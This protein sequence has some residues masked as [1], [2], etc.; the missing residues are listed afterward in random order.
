MDKGTFEQ[1]EGEETARR[2]A[3][4]GVRYW[5]VVAGVLGFL[6]FGVIGG[7]A[8]ISEISGAVIASGRMV[9]ESSPK[10][11]QHREGGI[12][13]EI[14][15]QNG[16]EVSA[17]DLLIRLDDTIVR[18]ELAAIEQ[19]LVHL[20]AEEA[21]HA[22]DLA[23]EEVLELRKTWAPLSDHRELVEAMKN[24]QEL[25]AAIRTTRRLET[26]QLRSKRDQII[27]ETRSH[28]ADL[29]AALKQLPMATEQLAGLRS[30]AAEEFVSKASVIKVE[31][32]AAELEARV[33]RARASVSRS[34][35][36]IK[37]IELAISQIEKGARSE[38]LSEQQR[39][40]GALL[41][42]AEKR[43]AAV[44]VLE[45][46]EIRAPRAGK[47]RA[48]AVHTIGGVI[49]PGEPIVTIV[50]TA[51]QLVVEASVQPT[52]IDQ[53]KVGQEAYVQFPGLNQKLTPRFAG[54]VV[55]VDADLTED[56]KRGSVY[57]LVRV[58]LAPD[59][60]A[61][62]SGLELVPGMPAEVYLTTY[63]RSP[64]SYLV[65]PLFDQIDHAMRED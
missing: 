56:A 49:G 43:S 58:A 32:E 6:L 39:V 10:V 9:V 27:E 1:G 18:A 26:E 21:R 60:E 7:W 62:A 40:G 37:E 64:L 50:P 19:R 47:V 30:L 16:D 4:G 45:R 29:Q 48:L 53:I 63:P 65:K 46:S 14:L 24:Q 5:T 33:A 17:G 22:A 31:G 59:N 15:I 3:Q 36:Q 55:H 13:S 34:Q 51:D 11:I 23:G 42:L 41:E 25:L 54:K 52:D 44:D 57:Y 20:V 8:A 28:E 12:I 2:V 61:F 38:A 35:A